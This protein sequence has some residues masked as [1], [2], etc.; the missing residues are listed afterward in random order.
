MLHG[1]G[2][3]ERQQRGPKNPD[4]APTLTALRVRCYRCQACGAV[5]RSAPSTVCY[6]RLYSA[7]AIG[8][9]LALWGLLQV[10]VAEVRARTSPW[11]IIGASAPTRWP[12]LRRWVKAVRNKKLFARVRRCPDHFSPKQVAERAAA[13]L[14][15]LAL[16]STATLPILAQAFYGAAHAG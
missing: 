13:T 10:S 8:F 5:I 15:G 3:K 16:A 11:K 6:R 9:A 12:T 7:P 1:H 2:T 14:S 4:G